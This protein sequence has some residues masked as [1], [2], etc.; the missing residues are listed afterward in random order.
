M[1]T[2]MAPVAELGVEERLWYSIQEAD[3]LLDVGG[4]FDGGAAGLIRT[5]VLVARKVGRRWMIEPAS[6]RRA[7]EIRRGSEAPDSAL[8]AAL[9][10]IEQL[11]TINDRL[12]TEL[13]KSKRPGRPGLKNGFE[14]LKRDGY[15]C[16][17]CGRSARVV[18]LEV[19][20]VIAVAAGGPDDPDNLVTACGDCNAGK[21]ARPAPPPP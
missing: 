15:R 14:I 5:G 19:D 11:R 21:G 13:A 2:V 4:R 17:Y 12:R 3:K 10:E 1:A 16:R 9:D 6:L 8:A 20:H 18:L 7:I